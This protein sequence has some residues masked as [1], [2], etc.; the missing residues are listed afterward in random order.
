MQGN[1]MHFEILVKDSSGKT[2]LEILVPRIID[3]QQHTYKIHTYKGIGHIPKGLT[4]NSD[5]RKRILLDQLPRLIQGYGITHAKSSDKFPS[6]LIVICDLDTKCLK[7]FRQ[8][9]LTC[10]DSCYP[11]PKTQFCIAIEEGEAW[12]LGDLAAVKKAY[13]KA[14]QKVLNEYIN[15]AIC[16]TWEKLADAVYR[17]GSSKLSKLGYQAIGTE[18]A[19][20]A[21]EITPFMDVD[22]N[23]SPS[24]CYFRDRLRQLG[25]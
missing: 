20:W 4:P 24:F 1:Y 6:V 16:R 14:K 11:Q 2:A 7:A 17:D 21:K 8:E 10:V 25:S 15:D 19:K 22:N 18:K 3:I 9:L 12:Y 23:Q 5:P 13:P